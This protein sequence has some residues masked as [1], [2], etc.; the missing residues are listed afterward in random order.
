MKCR[1]CG[2]EEHP[3][4]FINAKDLIA[5]CMCFSCDLWNRRVEEYKNS[6][7]SIPIIDGIYYSIGD[8]DSKSI[9]RGFGGARFQIEF[10]DG[11]K[12]VSTNL[13]CG[14]EVPEI[15]KDKLPDNARFENNLKW[16]K[17]G[18]NSYLI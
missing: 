7:H 1:I 13:W 5:E 2:C 4:R 12:V 16:Q 6:A 18:Q 15:W 8:E 10:N 14:S 3:N 11:F 17:I 9:S